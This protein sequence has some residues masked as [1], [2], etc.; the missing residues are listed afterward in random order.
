MT[1]REVLKHYQGLLDKFVYDLE[2]LKAKASVAE[3]RNGAK[4]SVG[5]HITMPD[6]RTERYLQGPVLTKTKE[7]WTEVV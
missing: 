7:G 3:V 2:Y 5:Y 1:K 6:G 4:L